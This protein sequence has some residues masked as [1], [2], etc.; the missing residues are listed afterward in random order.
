MQKI[1]STF[2]KVSIPSLKETTLERYILKTLKQT[3][4]GNR[5]ANMNLNTPLELLFLY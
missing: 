4:N 5:D 2:A 3:I 1:L